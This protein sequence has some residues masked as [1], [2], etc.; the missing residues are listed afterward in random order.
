MECGA[1]TTLRNKKEKTPR[2]LARKEE[3]KSLFE[4]FKQ[5]EGHENKSQLLKNVGT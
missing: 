3:I 2:D 1:D 5:K 4:E